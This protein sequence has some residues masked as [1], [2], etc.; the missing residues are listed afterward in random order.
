M[1]GKFITKVLLIVLGIVT[2]TLVILEPH[3]ELAKY[4]PETYTQHPAVSTTSSTAESDS[5]EIKSDEENFNSY[6]NSQLRFSYRYPKEYGNLRLVESQPPYASAT[7]THYF[8]SQLGEFNRIGAYVYTKG[9]DSGT[10]TIK[11]PVCP[12]VKN[13]HECEERTNANGEVFYKV[14]FWIHGDKSTRYEF[15]LN[16]TQSLVFYDSEIV[17]NSILDSVTVD[18]ELPFLDTSSNP[19]VQIISIKKEQPWEIKVNYEFLPPRAS[20]FRVCEIN[21]PCTE[22][23]STFTVLE[24]A[25]THVISANKNLPAGTYTVGVIGDSLSDLIVLS[26]RVEVK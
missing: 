20:A 2:L 16:P 1:S 7:T 10:E 22:P 19:R 17:Q 18:A 12:D 4:S 8:K 3:L 9:Y 13:I 23:V 5:S 15:P 11:E 24:G 26:N 14:D 6:K 25:G 21:T